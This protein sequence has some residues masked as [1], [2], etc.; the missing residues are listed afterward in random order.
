MTKCSCCSQLQWSDLPW[1]KPYIRQI[2]KTGE[3]V[4]NY[5]LNFFRDGFVD[6]KELHAWILRSFKSL[7]KE[8]SEERFDDGD[9][10]G[11]GFVSWLEYRRVEFD[12]DDD[13]DLES[14]K[15]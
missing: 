6:K 11:D 5:F 8:E 14:V 4:G 13:E 2:T 9:E 15:G 3:N 10:D 1:S 12:F 7:S